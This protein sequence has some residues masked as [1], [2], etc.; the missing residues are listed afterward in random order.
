MKRIFNKGNYIFYPCNTFQFFKFFFILRLQISYWIMHL[1]CH[2]E[3]TTTDD[4]FRFFFLVLLLFTRVLSLLVLFG[5]HHHWG[6]D[7]T[8]KST[9]R[10]TRERCLSASTPGSHQTSETLKKRPPFTQFIPRPDLRPN[11][12]VTVEDTGRF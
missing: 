6:K 1:Y 3:E 8:Q 10:G 4:Y 11:A 7:T 12:L 2:K 9:Q 5:T